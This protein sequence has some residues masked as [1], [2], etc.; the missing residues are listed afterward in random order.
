MNADLFAFLTTDT[1][2]EVKAIHPK[3]MPVILTTP[4]EVETWLAAP[5][6]E[7]RALQRPLPDAIVGG[8]IAMNKPAP[9][10]KLIV[11]MAL[12]DDGEGG[13]RPAFEPREFQSEQRAKIEA[14]W[15]ALTRLSSLGREMPSPISA[16]MAIR[17]YFSSTVQCRTWSD[18]SSRSG[19]DRAAS[20]RQRL[21]AARHRL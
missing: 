15:S 19:A 7:A 4:D 8:W 17:S 18:Q 14:G 20:S 5:W 6:R 13:L 21:V 10:T 11:V 16:S 3:A 1:N 12:E 9:A 2:A